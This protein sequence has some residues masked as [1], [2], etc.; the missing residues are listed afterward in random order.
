MGAPGGWRCQVIRS[1]PKIP[2]PRP[3]A[4]QLLRWRALCLWPPTQPFLTSRASP[5]GLCMAAL[6]RHPRRA[7]PLQTPEMLLLLG[8][9]LLCHARPPLVWALGHLHGVQVHHA[10]SLPPGAWTPRIG[11]CIQRCAAKARPRPPRRVHLLTAA[12]QAGGLARWGAPRWGA[13]RWGAPRWG[14]S[15]WGAPRWGAP[16]HCRSTAAVGA[17]GSGAGTGAAAAVGATA[18]ARSTAAALLR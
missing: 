8:V 17:A 12:Q 5:L 4:T 18:G 3:G 7:H 6:A 15:R 16:Q 14:A 2:H 11:D 10:A 13:P 9:L 1:C